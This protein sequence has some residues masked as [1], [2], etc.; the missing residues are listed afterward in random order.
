MGADL[1]LRSAF[2]KN[3]AKYAPKFSRWA[4]RRNAYRDLGQHQA[5]AE[6]QKQVSKY[7]QK[8]YERGYF[9]DSYNRSNLLWLFDLSWWEDLHNVL[10]DEHGVMNPEAAERFLQLLADRESAFEANLKKL[11]VIE[12]ET[13]EKVERYFRK[14]YQH[15]KAFLQKAIDRNES[16]DCSL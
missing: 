3:R 14:K 15:L 8:M 16:I 1:Y 10:T 11:E 12:G 7:Y 13:R 4:G 2:E 9:R 5:A 6:A